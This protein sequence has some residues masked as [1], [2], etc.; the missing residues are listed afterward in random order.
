MPNKGKTCLIER[1]DCITHTTAN[2][3]L[4]TYLHL[5]SS[6]VLAFQLQMNFLVELQNILHLK[7]IVML[8][9]FDLHIPGFS[10]LCKKL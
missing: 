2:T 4:I 1:P 7:D 6:L 3:E 8:E 5:S 10:L 9:H